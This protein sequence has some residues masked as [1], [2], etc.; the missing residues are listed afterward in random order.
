MKQTQ[1]A[2]QVAMEVGMDRVNA[3]S[4]MS[5]MWQSPGAADPLSP[6]IIMMVQAIQRCMVGMGVPTQTTG[7]VDPNTIAAF[8]QISGARWKQ[9]AFIQI[10]GDVLRA[11][12]TGFRFKAGSMAMGNYLSG[13]GYGSLG[14]FTS[15]GGIYKPSDATTL[16]TFKLLQDSTNRILATQKK[17]LIDVDGRIGPRTTSAVNAVLGTSLTAA[18]VADQ[19]EAL[20][21]QA[22]TL[23]ASMNAPKVK[24]PTS[25]IAPPSVALPSG[26]VKHPSDAAIMGAGFANVMSSPLGLIG[27]GAGVFLFMSMRKKKKPARKRK[28]PVRRRRPKARITRTYY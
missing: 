20:A 24:A 8:E 13:H 9:K 16:A 11:K 12:Q 27:I 15:S 26:E 14:D 28:A 7:H 21:S 22:T 10:F 4:A 2:V 1:T 19:A 6:T 23:A 25:K 5:F 3:T 17:R 18:Q